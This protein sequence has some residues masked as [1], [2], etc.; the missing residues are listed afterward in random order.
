MTKV[1]GESVVDSARVRLLAEQL[2]IEPEVCEINDV[3][4]LERVTDTMDKKLREMRKLIE[5]QKKHYAFK[6]YSYDSLNDA[7]KEVGY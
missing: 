5:E 3:E 2:G 7:L 1:R 6:K 4:C